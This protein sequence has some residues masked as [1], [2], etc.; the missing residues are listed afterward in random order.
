MNNRQ[1]MCYL[2][3]WPIGFPDSPVPST[4]TT[5][6]SDPGS[7]PERLAKT[8]LRTMVTESFAKLMSNAIE[9][10]PDDW[11]RPQPR[12]IRRV[13]PYQF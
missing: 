2:P 5:P 13:E 3:T 10:G 9:P 1:E 7:R 8:D 12:C 4:S 11:V 6:L